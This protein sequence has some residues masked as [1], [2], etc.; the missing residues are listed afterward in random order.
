MELWEEAPIRVSFPTY[1]HVHAHVWSPCCGRFTCAGSRTVVDL[2]N[3]K[4]HPTQAP[5]VIGYYWTLKAS[6]SKMRSQ[7][8]VVTFY[9]VFDMGHFSWLLHKIKH[10]QTHTS[11]L[12]T[13]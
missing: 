4:S 6:Y 10:L 8:V 1:N 2:Q 3:M 13:T 7:D 11:N 9:V 12:V 5:I